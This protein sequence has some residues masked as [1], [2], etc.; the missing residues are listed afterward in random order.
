M[1]INRLYVVSH[2]KSINVCYFSADYCRRMCY[3]RVV[4]RFKSRCLIV[5]K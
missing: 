2:C 1:I 5:N 3:G 4:I